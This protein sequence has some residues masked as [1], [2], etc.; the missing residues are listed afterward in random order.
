MGDDFKEEV[1]EK[2]ASATGGCFYD[3]R[4]AKKLSE[5]YKQIDR[6]ESEK[7]KTITITKTRHYAP[8][9]LILALI[10]L[11]LLLLLRVVWGA[12]AFTPLLAMLLILYA[13][14]SPRLF[15]QENSKQEWVNLLVAIECS[16]SMDAKD[17]YPDRFHFAIHKL[18]LLLDS[19][20]RLR[21]GVLLFCKKSYM[22]VP[23]TRDYEAI[24]SMLDH[25]FIDRIERQGS[26]WSALLRSASNFREQNTTLPLIVF[27]TGEGI[28]D[29]RLLAHSAKRRRLDLILIPA[30]TIK[31]ATISD[32]KE[33]LRNERGDVI[34][35]RLNPKLGCLA[36][37][38]GG[39]YYPLSLDDE[40]IN[41]LAKKI[42]DR[43]SLKAKSKDSFASKQAPPRLPTLLALALLSLPWALW[44]RRRR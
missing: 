26:N 3:A 24:K 28:D 17:L 38:A 44:I 4:Q 39:L 29:C 15:S 22:L 5:I 42:V 2:I 25:L 18:R 35:S 31:G 41:R 32:G 37:E 36:K 43:Y 14:L 13:L 12:G 7:I 30:A 27:A 1:L 19:S 40:D 8:I 16:N 20:K 11:L 10:A 34:I 9:A 6:I 23:P 33:L 21:V